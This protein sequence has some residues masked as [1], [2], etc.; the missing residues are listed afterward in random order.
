MSLFW[1][2]FWAT[3]LAS[4]AFVAVL[5]FLA[6]I[7]KG[8]LVKGLKGF[9]STEIIDAVFL[10]EKEKGHGHDKTKS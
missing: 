4:L 10:I 5:S 7:A 6:Y 9:I 3:F 2:T 8:K 1:I